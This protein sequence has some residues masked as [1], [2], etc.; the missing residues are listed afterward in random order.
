MAAA[1]PWVGAYLMVLALWAIALLVVRRPT[2]W[3][4]RSIQ[5]VNLVFM[6][7]AFA[8]LLVTR[9]R[10]ATALNFFLLILLVIVQVARGRLIL[11][12]VEREEVERTVERCLAQTRAGYERRGEDY[13]VS[14]AGNLVIAMR[15]ARPAI[16][17]EF[18]NGA[19]SKKAELI[20]ALFRKQFNGSFPTIRVPT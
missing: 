12:H 4:G 9:Q 2:L 8:A 6:W 14:N 7:L 17:I 13:V 15:G 18:R 3:N 19:A 16:R 10:P 1:A 20:E 11:F 5:W